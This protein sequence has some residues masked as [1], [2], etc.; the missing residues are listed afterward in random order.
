MDAGR[1][2]WRFACTERFIGGELLVGIKARNHDQERPR[3]EQNDVQP[4]LPNS[5]RQ[6]SITP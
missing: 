2:P 3:A 4:I 5:H 1:T 6:W